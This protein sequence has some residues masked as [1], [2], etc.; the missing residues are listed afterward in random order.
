MARLFLLF[1]ILFSYAALAQDQNGHDVSIDV[2]LIDAPFNFLNDK[3]Y[4]FPSMRQSAEV[5]TDFLQLG[6]RLIQGP[7]INEQRARIWGIVAFDL[8]M[9]W[10]PLGSSWM[11]EEFHRATMS[12]RG[13][14]SYN[15]VNRFPIGSDLIAVSHVTDEDLT[16]FK[17]D[18]PAEFVRMSAAGMESQVV[19]NQIIERRHFFD[20]AKSYDF[21]TL[22]VN[23]INVSMYLKTCGSREADDSTDSQNDEDGANVGKRDF[24]GLDCTAWAYDLFRPDEPYAA[25][26]THPSGVG[27]DRYIRYSDLNGREKTFLER[28]W[29]LSLL[30]FADPAMYGIDEFKYGDWRWNARLS[31]FITSFGYV[32]DAGLLAKLGR[33][34]FTFTLHN[35]FNNEA[36]FP[37]VTAEWYEHPLTDKWNVTT[38]LTLWNQPEDQRVLASSAETL[39]AGG[40]RVGYRYSDVLQPYVGIEGKTPGWM[41]GNVFLDRNVSIWT[42]L[43]A[44]L[45]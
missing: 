5:S 40:V 32:V 19:Q 13:I 16:R 8:V 45:F 14:G 9:E 1:S 24:T 7:R 31:H 20:D 23:N 3:G 2:P 25:R 17:R 39:V 43:K 34:K 10:V 11:H 28:Q 33:E 18:H 26:G 22:F 21:I 30:N 6:H 41:A 38:S 4:V 35:G 37:G 15:D 29:I 36:Y 42:G 12:R 27:I 44:A